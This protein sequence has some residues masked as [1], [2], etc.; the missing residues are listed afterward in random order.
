MQKIVP[1]SLVV[2]DHAELQYVTDLES[3][4]DTWVSFDLQL[5]GFIAYH[6][7]IW[8]ILPSVMFLHMFIELFC[9][10]VQFKFI[11]TV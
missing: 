1:Q 6:L 7:L 3:Q 10:Y 9:I 4:A 11:S 5:L 8:N 2:Q